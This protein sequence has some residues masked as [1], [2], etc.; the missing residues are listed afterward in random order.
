M[1]NP[2]GIMVPIVTPFCNNA[3]DFDA[4]QRIAYDLANE[5]V[6]GII[7]CGT[8]GEAA[9]LDDHEQTALLCAVM[10]A[11]GSRCPV[12]MGVSGSN[13]RLVA[14]KIASFNQYAP[15]GFLLS[16]PSYVRPSQNGI[17]LHFQAVAARTDLPIVIY[18]I[19]AR[20][21]VNIATETVVALA[22]DPQFVAIK[23][24]SGNLTQLAE[25]INSKSLKVLS[26]DDALFLSTLRLGGHG[27]ISAAAH[28]RPDLFLRV[29]EL[30]KL[31]EVEQATSIFNGLLALIRLLFSEPNPGPIKAAL[32][33]Q[34]KLQ[35][36]LRLPMTTM[37]RAGQEQLAKTLEDVMA[38][39]IYED[40]SSAR[41]IEATTI[42]KRSL[43]EGV[44]QTAM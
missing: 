22:T 23:E 43:G 33:M 5:G 11:V 44:F 3:I 35:Q 19:P 6:H 40:Q 29:Y 41:W 34:G 32:A 2:E 25:I 9:A 37:S 8:T 26:G 18:N 12:L 13:T 1:L 20:T 38:L 17:L 27:A 10:E 15:A 28:I 42:E 14:E 31:G 7:V 21:G 24:S 4:A 16:P 39:P 30:M 36:N